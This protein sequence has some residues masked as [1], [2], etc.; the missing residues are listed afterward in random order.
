MSIKSFLRAKLMRLRSE[1]STEELVKLGLTVGNN[2][3]RQEKTLIDQSHC[4]LINIG[5]DVTL[6]PRVHILAHDASTKKSLGYT[7]IGFVN[8]GNN[9]F[10]GASSTVLPGVK[11]GDNVVIGAGSV[12]SK[13]IPSNSVAVGN[14][15]K[16]ICSYNDFV[17]RKKSEMKNT[18]VFDEKYTLRNPNITSE[19]KN[20]MKKKLLENN[21]VGYVE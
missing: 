1:I 8:I 16:V 15:A 21:G 20:E 14:P 7:R 13:D 10:I 2:F 4:W 6:A 11:I 18:T 17:E 5:N 9:V 12:V 3:S 19:M